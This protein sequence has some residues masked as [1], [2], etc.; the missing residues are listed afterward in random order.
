MVCE[1]GTTRGSKD[2]CPDA[3]GGGIQHTGYK[4]RIIQLGN[5]AH[6]LARFLLQ[7]TYGSS[8]MARTTIPGEAISDQ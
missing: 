1:D 3:M 8:G 6:I 7:Q 4:S 5:K 2:P